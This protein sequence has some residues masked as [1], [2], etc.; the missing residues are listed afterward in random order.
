MHGSP[1]LPHK[2]ATLPQQL[3]L[4]IAVALAVAAA[5]AA[6]QSFAV[7]RLQ[8]HPGHTA[9]TFVVSEAGFQVVTGNACCPVLLAIAARDG[10][11]AVGVL[12]QS[13]D[14]L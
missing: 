4:V 8:G 10:D 1:L 5:L 7:P 14:L 6:R 13:T 3:Q 11:I 9:V 12:A 2:M